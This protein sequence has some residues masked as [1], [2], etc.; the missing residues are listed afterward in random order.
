MESDLGSCC[1]GPVTPQ[2]AVNAQETKR[3]L[4][5][6]P[7]WSPTCLSYVGRT[8]ASYMSCT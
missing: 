7:L 6:E 4:G 2:Y 8:I 3:I 1:K 5:L